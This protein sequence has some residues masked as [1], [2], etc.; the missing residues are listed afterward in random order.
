MPTADQAHTMLG[1]LR[2]TAN[3]AGGSLRPS[4][5]AASGLLRRSPAR[6]FGPVMLAIASRGNL[7]EPAAPDLE[8]TDN[9]SEVEARWDA[10]GV[11]LARD[12]RDLM[13]E[14]G[15]AAPAGD[16]R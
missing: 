4:T 5:L 9:P 3:H 11:Q 2:S 13:N 6:Q 7:S 15:E 12:L 16:A 8:E 10:A 1:L 14:A